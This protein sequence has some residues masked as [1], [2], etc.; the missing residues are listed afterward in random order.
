MTRDPHAAS[1]NP[2]W[3]SICGHSGIPAAREYG[4]VRGNTTRFRQTTYR[5]WKCPRCSTIHSLDP[6]D[7]H[8][9]YRGYPL[10]KRRIDVYSRGTLRNLTR[11]LERAGMGTD[12]AILDYGCGNGLYLRYLGGRGYGRVFGYDPF[13]P[14]FADFPRAEAPFDVV[15]NND[16]LEHCDDL[17]S[18]LRHCV[19]ILRPGGLLYVGTADSEPVDMADLE[20]H[21]MRLHQPFHRVIITARTLEGLAAELELEVLA[22]YRRSYQDTLRP[23][24]NYRFLDELNRV[25]GHELD[26]A[27]DPARSTRAF[28]RN[29]RLWFFALFG[30]LF[31]SAEEPALVLRKPASTGRR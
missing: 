9:I 11:R 18:V 4:E 29:P 24:S 5:L 19:D 27:L 13:V 31:P 12:Q 14:E 21:V 22:R 26:R 6:V 30:F 20:P 17:R 10:E 8:D 23:F 1:K 3:C 15:V 28:L 7:F 2:L 25:L 16:T